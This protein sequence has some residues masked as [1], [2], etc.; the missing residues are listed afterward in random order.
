MDVCLE[1]RG[2]IHPPTAASP[3]LPQVLPVSRLWAYRPKAAFRYCSRRYQGEVE[4]EFRGDPER[5]KLWGWG[6]L[7]V[8]VLRCVHCVFAFQE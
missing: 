5:E 2:F 6:V 1:P 7:I 3:P 4:G 8:L